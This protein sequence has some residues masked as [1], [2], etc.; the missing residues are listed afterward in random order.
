MSGQLNLW[1]CW[2]Q[3]LLDVEVWGGHSHWG[4][5]TPSV[6]GRRVPRPQAGMEKE[7]GEGPGLRSQAEIDEAL[8]ALARPQLAVTHQW[9][10]E[11]YVEPLS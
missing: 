3:G 4:T 10:Y 5:A 8:A 9:L 7:M 6:Q 2:G 11:I 1:V